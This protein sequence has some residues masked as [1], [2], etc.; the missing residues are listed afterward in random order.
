M[1]RLSKPCNRTR[2]NWRASKMNKISP[3]IIYLQIILLACLTICNDCSIIS[4][5]KQADAF[6]CEGHQ[7]GCKS[8]YDCKTHCC[9]EVYQNHVNFQ[10]NENEQKNSF[11]VFISSVNCKYG[12]DPLISITFMVKYIL[13]G[14]VRPIKESFLCF[15]SQDISIS[16]LKVFVSRPK[17][18]PRHFV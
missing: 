5:P 3:I 10:H 13:E 9:C 4:L 14:K 17:K 11:Q 7:C 15:L 12:N 2:G 8:A 1:A 18:P 16:P 6:L